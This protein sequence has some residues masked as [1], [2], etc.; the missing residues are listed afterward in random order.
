MIINNPNES[1][2]ARII[3]EFEKEGI[4]TGAEL[5]FFDRYSGGRFPISLEEGL[6]SHDSEILDSLIDEIN[7]REWM[8]SKYPEELSQW[9]ERNRQQ[10]NIMNLEGAQSPGQ[11]RYNPEDSGFDLPALSALIQLMKMGGSSLMDS[12]FGKKSKPPVGNVPGADASKLPRPQR[13]KEMD[14]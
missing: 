6:S 12:I 9:H 14:Y 11:R 13:N 1:R 8:K 10:E 4:T 5:G 2:L 3:R 7:K